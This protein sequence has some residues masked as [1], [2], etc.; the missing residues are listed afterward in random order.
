MDQN[1]NEPADQH[2]PEA[3]SGTLQRWL[4]GPRLTGPATRGAAHS[5]PR[6]L[7]F[8]F[9][10][11]KTDALEPPLWTCIERLAPLAPRFVSVTYGADGSHAERTHGSSRASR[12]RPP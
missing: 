8:E 4:T 6:T 10:P 2:L 7:S 1:L 12:R 9:F 5:R 11:P 3:T